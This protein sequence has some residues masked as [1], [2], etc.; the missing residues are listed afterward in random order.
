[1]ATVTKANT[2][3]ATRM[4]HHHDDRCKYDDKR[5]SNRD[6]DCALDQD[7]DRGGAMAEY[8]WSTDEV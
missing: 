2:T 1:M 3:T 7:N 8:R 6:N 4:A 5:A